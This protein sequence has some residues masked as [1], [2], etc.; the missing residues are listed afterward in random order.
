MNKL[1]ENIKEEIGNTEALIN[2]YT[3]T[4]NP[5]IEILTPSPFAKLNDLKTALELLEKYNMVDVECNLTDIDLK[6]TR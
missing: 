3:S 6:F 5:T 4:G 1:I 2:Y